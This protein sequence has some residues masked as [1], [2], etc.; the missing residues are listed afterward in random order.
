MLPKLSFILALASIFSFAQTAPRYEVAAI[1]PNK[2]G[3]NG[4]SINRSGNRIT[5]ENVSMRE[6]ISF[7]YSIPAGR[8][9][10][11]SG[12]PWIDTEKFDINASFSLDG[13]SSEDAR[14][15]VRGMTRALLDERFGMKTHRQ[16]KQVKAYS[17]TVSKNGPRLTR[18]NANDGSFNYREG[19]IAVRG[20]SI[21]SFAA[22]LSDTTFHLDRPVVDKTN[23]A[24]A[25]DFTME[26]A[27]DLGPTNA[28]SGPSLFT[29][30][31]EQLGL[32]LDPTETVIDVLIVDELARIPK[33][34]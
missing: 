18:S 14:D 10:L 7:A 19:R 13:I 3:V 28:P 31:E 11:L 1:R 26:W 20:F 6:I 33:D 4:S 27:P 34:N 30:I 16:S 12:P 25:Y 29:A 23:L 8:N 9:Y 32:K 17:L 2:S 5:F 21:A 24:G 22:R 15:A